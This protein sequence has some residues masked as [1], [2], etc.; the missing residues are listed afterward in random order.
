MVERAPR[1]C[2]SLS[3]A[4]TKNSSVEVWLF[5]PDALALGD[6]VLERGSDKSGALIA[7]V[8]RGRYS[9]ALIWV[10]GDFIEAMPEGVRS[11]SFARV[12]VCEPDNWLLLR[13]LPEHASVAA[14]A[15][16][17]ARGMA[18]KEYDTRGAIRTVIGPRKTPVPTARFCSQLVAEAYLR[19]GLDLLPGVTPEAVTPNMLLRSERLALVP[20]PLR[21]SDEIMDEPYPYDM[22]DRSASYLAS[23]MYREA[24]I[25][26]RLFRFVE[27]AV[28][29]VLTPELQPYQPGNLGEVLRLLP[30]LEPTA[31]SI[32]ADQLLQGMHQEGYFHLLLPQFASMWSDVDADPHWRRQIPGWEET[33]QRH[34]GNARFYQEQ[35]E[36]M[37]HQLW[38]RLHTMHLLIANTFRELIEKAS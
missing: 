15:A 25:S 33:R 26:R 6:I 30:H 11:L 37:P 8:T 38:R 31:A 36:V 16:M 20:L 34:L 4:S 24:L 13:P 32:I 3:M 35:D 2:R 29:S 12:P 1:V 28:N 19:S 7:K 21:R 10:G 27:A 18:H 23:P 22:L 17:A 5:D 14:E 9:H